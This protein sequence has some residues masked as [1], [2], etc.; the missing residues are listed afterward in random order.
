MFQNL[1]SPYSSAHSRT[2]ASAEE[3]RSGDGDEEDSGEEEGSSKEGVVDHREAGEGRDS[4]A[5]E[6]RGRRLHEGRS[7]SGTREEGC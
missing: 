3:G 1:L 5:E 4:A 6:G 2:V 7:R